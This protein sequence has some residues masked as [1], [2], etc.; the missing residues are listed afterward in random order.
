MYVNGIPSVA[1][2][3]AGCQLK[4]SEGSND[5]STCCKHE[6]SLTIQYNTIQIKIYIAP[7]SLIKRDR[8]DGWSARW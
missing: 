1:S 7:N 4:T 8:G 6:T 2:G 3:F 5:E